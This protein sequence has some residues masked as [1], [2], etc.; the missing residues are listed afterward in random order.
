M[1][2][3]TWTHCLTTADGAHLDL[4][5]GPDESIIEAAEQAGMLLPS[6]CRAGNCGACHA[7]ATGDYALGDHART[8]LDDD[9]AAC[10]DVLL[11][12]TY[13]HGPLTITLPYEQGRIISGR[14]PERTATVTAVTQVAADTIG[15]ELALDPD[16]QGAGC[17]FDPG[18]FLELTIPGTSTRRSYSLANTPNWDGVA[19]LFIKLREGGEFSRFLRRV[20]PGQ[21]LTVRGPQGAFGIR[22]TGIRPRWFIAGGTGLSPLLSM[23]ERMAEWAEP[24][25]SRL[26]FG[27]RT[28]AEIFGTDV[29]DALTR[30]LPGFRYEIVV[31][32]PSASWRGRIGTPLDGLA[33][34]LEEAPAAPDIYVCGPP[35]MV[36]ATRRIAR[37]AGLSDDRVVVENF[38]PSAA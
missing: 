23:L 24:H 34:A 5:S 20:T 7:H 25:P 6:S 31:G 27:V 29:M 3:T 35:G 36:A 10:G 1:S 15:L 16:Q 38:A 37:Q 14:I 4:H 22:D 17:E 12:R 2:T 8:V 19:E 9:S 30:Q 18:Q 32:H 26:W 13:A 33:E 11:C 21:R 28:E